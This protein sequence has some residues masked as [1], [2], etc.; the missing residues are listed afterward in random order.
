MAEGI[1]CS[2]CG[3]ENRSGRKFCA[4][5]GA[6]LARACPACGAPNE[7]GERFCGECGARLEQ[8][9]VVST[10]A[11]ERRLVTVLFADLV[12]FT[13]LS[14]R[15]DAEEVRDLL[16]RYFDSARQLIERYGG[17][18]EKFIGDA[19]MAVW[20]TPVA[21]EDD[22]ERAVRAA[23][24]FVAMVGVLGVEG[25]A[26]RAGVLTGEAA[27]TVGASGEG[28]VAGDLVNTAS[29]IQSVAEP[30]T[31]FVGERTRRASE[32]AIGYQDAGVHELKGKEERVQLWRA[33]RVTAARGGG[34]KAEALEP[35]FVG[36]EREFRL[37]K[38]LFH[39]TADERR[40][41]LV[42]VVG[43][44]GIGK[45]RLAW[46]FYKYIDGLTQRVR[47][48]RG[49]CLAYGE[50]VAYWA[51]AEMVRGRAGILE[52]ED[53]ESSR[54]KLRSM[55]EEHVGDA[56]EREWI[57]PRL[58][59][60]LA[61]EEGSA[62]DR[63]DLFAG[64]RLFLE[65]M[66]ERDPVA[67][68]FED[69]QWADT[70][71]L[72]FVDHLLEWS[73]NRPI[74]VLA[75][76]RPDLADR[77]PNWPSGRIGLTTLALEPLAQEAMEALLDGLA[78]GLP[79]DLRMRIL[80]Q[81]EGVPLYAVETVRMLLDR[82][83]LERR[84]EEFITTAT[85]DEL[86]VP[87]TLHALVAARLDA[88][89]PAERGLVQD[90]S[91]L[92]KMFTVGRLGA[93]TGLDAAAIEPLLGALVRKEIFTVQA[94]PRS[95]ERG[96]YGFLQDLVR[97]VA[98]E[99]L[100]RSDRKTR[101]LAVAAHLE[102]E[103]RTLGD[104]IVEVV[105]SHYVSA[106]QLDTRAADAA[107]LKTKA[108]TMLG[109]AGERAAT[110]AANEEAQRYFERALELAESP[111]EQ[112]ELHERAGRTARSGGRFVEAR[113]HFE[114]AIVLFESIGLTHPGARVSARLAEISWDEGR[115]EEAIADMEAALAVLVEEEHDADLAMLAAQLGRLLYFSGRR[116]EA[117]ERVEFA[118]EIAEALRLPEVLSHALNTKS[119]VL[120]ARGRREEADVL[121][122]HALE[123]ALEEDLHEAALRAY[124]NLA[125]ATAQ[126]GRDREALRLVRGATTLARKV[127]HRD[128]ELTF[129]ISEAQTLYDLG[130][131]DEALSLTEALAAAES[132]S[133][134]TALM[135]SY[136][137]LVYAAR[138]ELEEARRR[139]EEVRETSEAFD[140]LFRSG[141]RALDAHVLL[142]EGK[143]H[144]ALTA[145]EDV[146]AARLQLGM[147]P[148]RWGL[149]AALEAAFALGDDGKVDELLGIIEQLPPG[150]LVPLVQAD[151]SRF[152]AR[153]AALQGDAAAADAGYRAATRL[154]RE[155]EK[156]F[157]CALAELEHGEWLVREGRADDAEPLLAE[158]RYTFER[159]RARPFL[160]RVE[161]ARAASTETAP[162]GV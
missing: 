24:D 34:M 95:P 153:R 105:A 55:L 49:R 99:T 110:L 122:R 145:A 78:P 120:N 127:G 162:A 40:A 64:W 57:E 72:D 5:C 23:L 158:A 37:V 156:P 29:R 83:L 135:L 138:G 154:Y 118:L 116:D 90:A 61:L 115:I 89:T 20:G 21:Q 84:G 65:R 31:V 124:N 10:P 11:V 26:A 47:W 103:W 91:V 79:A 68:V 2:S 104:E 14:E 15:R 114:R 143:L 33:L 142:A 74:F 17:T 38:E 93:V 102:R 123:V 107:E 94:D 151:G 125:V 128:W 30:D 161:R 6:P 9:P 144:D 141:I 109:R 39:A 28:M 112:A 50:G 25:L 58:A 129:R 48:H 130:E 86:A 46:E 152:A 43:I 159:L 62:H 136:A 150:Q 76:T 85:I 97:Q 92:G 19:V 27:V 155:I 8:E 96:Q 52:A 32:A 80:E 146:L 45:S 88:L 100:A 126:R 119:V 101:H 59:H 147:E 7:P 81:A 117:L 16:S 53:P 42:S 71:L 98:Y 108:R 82:G 70:S 69:M 87:E 140:L 3:R 4:E 137:A 132:T 149:P 134:R 41:H 139:V 106:Y 67:L 13:G 63:A 36:R 148:V 35:P 44:A 51:L 66:S 160:E 75:L 12:G 131:W 1:T 157:E 54:A 77:H 22:A 113:S 121:L 60:L 56:E 18:V 73:R 111:L 133:S